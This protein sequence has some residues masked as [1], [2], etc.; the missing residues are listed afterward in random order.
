MKTRMKTWMCVGLMAGMMAPAVQGQLSESVRNEGEA[1]VRR[2]LLWLL[3]QQHEGGHWSSP[4]WPAL[5]A[6]PVWALSLSEFHDSEAVDRGVDRLLSLAHEN[7]AIF[8]EPAEDRRGGG[9][10][11]YNTAIS[12]TALHLTGRERTQVPVLRAREYMAAAQHLG[13][14]VFFGGF[15]Y[16]ATTER[17]YADLSNTYIA[18]EAMRMTEDAEDFRTE[19]ERVDFN[20]SA[21]ADF[22]TRTQNLRETNPAEWVSD[23][24]EDRGGFAY[25]P[26]SSRDFKRETEDG[27]VAFRSFGSM[28][29]AGMLS[30]IYADVDRDDPR[31]RSAFEWAARHW[32]LEGN[33]NPGEPNEGLYYFY[34]VLSKSLAAYGQDR[35]PR[36]GGG[37]IDW[38]REFVEKLVS[39]QKIDEEG[40]GYWVNDNNR[41]WEGNQVLVTAYMLIALQV[42]L[43]EPEIVE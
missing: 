6:L 33:I 16:D 32:T 12:M 3:A 29:Y 9:M 28:T 14:D 10:P 7:G 21:A 35:L 24:P 43:A 2:G 39:V 5:T 15:G 26:T 38:R 37:E 4:E 31:V 25:H 23:H 8:V 42:V 40:R 18:L 22:V 1:A 34:N 30:L 13:D 20:R 19:G 11:M 41:Y 36:E 17:A 27:R